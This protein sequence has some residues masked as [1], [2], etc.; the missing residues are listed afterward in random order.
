MYSWKSQEMTLDEY[1]KVVEE[2]RKALLALK[3]GDERKVDVKEFE[4]MQVLTNKKKDED[5][6]FMKVVRNIYFL[7]LWLLYLHFM[8]VA[9]IIFIGYF[10]LLFLN[11]EYLL[12]HIKGL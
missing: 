6:I 2:K 10:R 3:K 11:V 1:E 4:P 8:E 7:F 5:A 9:Y 12:Y